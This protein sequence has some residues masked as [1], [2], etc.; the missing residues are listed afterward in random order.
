MKHNHHWIGAANSDVVKQPTA[1][2]IARSVKDGYA[3]MLAHRR[4]AGKPIDN[5]ET[6]GW[7]RKK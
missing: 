1:S 7:R 3:A 5:L 4:A 6:R 2:A